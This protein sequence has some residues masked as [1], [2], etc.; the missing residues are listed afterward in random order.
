MNNRLEQ[1]VEEVESRLTTLTPVVREQEVTEI[2]QHLEAMVAAEREMGASEKEATDAAISRF[3]MASQVGS[4]LNATGWRLRLRRL[5]DVAVAA[6]SAMSVWLIIQESTRWSGYWATDLLLSDCPYRSHDD[7][8]QL[9]WWLFRGAGGLLATVVLVMRSGWRAALRR[10]LDPGTAEGA[11]ARCIASFYLIWHVEM[12]A[13]YWLTWRLTGTVE[14]PQSLQGENFYVHA[15]KAGVFLDIPPLLLAYRSVRK[16]AP[17]KAL[18]VSFAALVTMYA[19]W[20]ISAFLTPKESS[21]PRVLA[22]VI[23]GSLLMLSITVGLDAGV[24]AWA[25]RRARVI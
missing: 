20:L 16:G 4:E 3:G 13:M 15:W 10:V 24:T 19:A 17:R 21:S 5:P 22:V 2:R 23:A 8:H 12:L 7:S 1:F 14:L 25:R 11:A 6:L 9:S 18:P